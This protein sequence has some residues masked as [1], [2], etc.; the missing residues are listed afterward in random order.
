M[1]YLILVAVLMFVGCKSTQPTDAQLAASK[2]AGVELLSIS[3][4]NAP[5]ESVPYVPPTYVTAPM[6]QT[7][8][9]HRHLGPT[10]NV[11]PPGSACYRGPQTLWRPR[12]FFRRQ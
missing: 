5:E 11:C 12:F 8:E 3:A 1:K 6:Y 9:D 4:A 7:I 2:D 10:T